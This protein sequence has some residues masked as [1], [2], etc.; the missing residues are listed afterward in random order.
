MNIFCKLLI[1]FF[2]SIPVIAGASEKQ[3]SLLLNRL[4][5]R[6]FETISQGYCLS[7]W[8]MGIGYHAKQ[9]VNNGFGIYEEM[10]SNRARFL[11][12]RYRK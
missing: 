9:R 3:A 6:P 10:Y 1:V 4:K 7:S 2:I 12:F 8:F 5:S 11:P